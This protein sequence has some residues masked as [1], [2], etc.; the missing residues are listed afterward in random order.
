MPQQ[1][2]FQEP[3]YPP[4]R[5]HWIVSTR[6]VYTTVIAVCGVI[7]PTKT[8]LG[9]RDS[10]LASILKFGGNGK[11]RTFTAH[12]MKVLHYHYATLPYVN[13]LRGGVLRRRSTKLIVNVFAYGRTTRTRTGIDRVKADY[14]TFE[15]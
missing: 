11:S 6:Q 8:V 2:G 14:S 12:R 4:G 15:L 10:N 13:T 1:K 9:L 7:Q 5:T 3:N